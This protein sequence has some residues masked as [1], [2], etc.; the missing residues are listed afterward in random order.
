MPNVT[1]ATGPVL[2]QIY[3]DTFSIW[4]DGLTRPDYERFNR[5]QMMTPW[6]TRNLERVAWMDGETLLASAK[7]YRLS[8]SFEGSEVPCLGIGAVFT[9]PA[10]R[11]RGHAAALIEALSAEAAREGTEYVFLYSEIDPEYYARQGFE[12]IPITESTI[13]LKTQPRAGAP[14]VL[15]RAGDERDIQNIAE[16]HQ[17][18][19]AKYAF[20]QH[21]SP[22]YVRHALAKR[23]MLAAFSPPG[24]RQ[25][26]FF[27]A[28][29]AASAVA[30]V[31]I[32][33][34]PEGDVLEEWGDRDPTGA[35]A[36]AMLQ[37]MAARTPAETVAPLRTWMPR[38]FL[39]PQIERLDERAPHETAMIRSST[40]G[41][42]IAAPAADGVFLFKTD[43]F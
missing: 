20:A 15:V 13:G 28:E 40:P 8:L 39:P 18:R 29:E 6:G 16:M 24:V 19:A 1:S 11:G 33:R 12:T 2:Q 3:D 21:R 35:R 9:P 17:V 34:G 31:V 38:D 14:A 26:E 27:I 43:A 7:R 41:K 10:L 23:R 32:S 36:G 4:S 42:R 30:Y 22:D 37:V 25:L 5:A